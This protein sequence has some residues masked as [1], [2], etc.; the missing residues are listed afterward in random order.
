MLN[1]LLVVA[2]AGFAIGAHQLLPPILER[3]TGQ[4]VRKPARSSVGMLR[5]C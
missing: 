5:E 4:N 2:S 3:L 1:P